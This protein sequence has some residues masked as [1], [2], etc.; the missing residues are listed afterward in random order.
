MTDEML[1]LGA[2][3]EKTP[4]ADVLREMIGFAAVQLMEP[5]V[6]GLTGRLSDQAFLVSLALMAAAVVVVGAAAGSVPEI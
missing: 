2:L 1:N 3:V 5:Q 4:D 6:G